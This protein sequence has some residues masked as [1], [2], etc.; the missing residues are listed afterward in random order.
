MEQCPTCSAR[1][2]GGD[3]C[4]RCQ[5]DLRQVLA[6]ERAARYHRLQ[7][8]QALRRGCVSEAREHAQNACDFHRS[9]DSVKV[10]AITT[11]AERNFRATLAL[12]R[13]YASVR[14]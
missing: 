8:G 5:T 1:Y 11:L 14:R 3:S 6:V 7:A 13:E 2:R 12:W 9:P 4:H 10:L